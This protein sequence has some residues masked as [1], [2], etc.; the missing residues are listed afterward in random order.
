MTFNHPLD[1]RAPLSASR[2]RRARPTVAITLIVLA[3]STV[4]AQATKPPS[5]VHPPAAISAIREADL[6]RDMYALA[7]DELR[8]REAGTV[9]EMRASMW[10]ADEMRKIGLTPRGEGGSWFQWW[11]MRR[12]RISTASSAISLAGRPL[13]LWS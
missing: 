5:S 13:A 2:R 4:N 3:A 10:L 11:N 9:D 6:K 8:G 7:G 12:T 1:A